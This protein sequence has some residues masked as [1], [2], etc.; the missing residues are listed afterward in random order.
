VIYLWYNNVCF[1]NGV[2]LLDMY[3]KFNKYIFKIYIYIIKKN[4]N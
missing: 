2:L 1:R 4:F 3:S